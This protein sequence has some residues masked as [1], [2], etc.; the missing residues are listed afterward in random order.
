MGCINVSG[1]ARAPIMLYF[2]LYLSF[3]CMAVTRLCNSP[4]SQDI[5]QPLSAA[6]LIAFATL[7][8]LIGFRYKVGGDW[9]S[10]EYHVTKQI[11]MPFSTLIEN[12]DP[13]YFLLSWIGANIGG[14]IFFVNLMCACLFT[15]GLITFSRSQT[16]PWL[17]MTLA[18]PYLITVVA[19]GYTRQAVAISLSMI[20]MIALQNGYI[21]RFMFWLFA[22]C[23]FHKTA[24][25]LAPIALFCGFSRWYVS[26]PTVSLSASLIFILFLQGALEELFQNYII[27]E[28]QSDGAA[29]RVIMT[30]L[31]AVIFLLLRGRFQ[32]SKNQCRFW[33]WMA[34]SGLVLV[35]LLLF[36]PSS[37][38][39]DRV[40]LYWIPLQ[41]YVFSR[42]PDILGQPSGVSMKW[43]LLILVYGL[44]TL[45]VWL[46]FATH[47]SYWLPYRFYP[48]EYLWQ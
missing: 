20:G 5:R 2:L 40:A 6:W 32:L 7:V 3:A 16:R 4:F 45:L 48:W 33:T 42:L 44:M 18:V 39:V 22:A 30:A 37:T 13:A 1:L 10:Y 24:I 28:Y 43:L 38:A 17:V 19:M 35:A 15:C 26:I 31:P 11:N 29:I 34:L 8:C 12:G 9:D 27:N 41:L 21:L 46:L 36:L 47:A 25:V 23:L 14:G